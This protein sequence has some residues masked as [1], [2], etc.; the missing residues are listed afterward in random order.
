VCFFKPIVK[1]KN[2]NQLLFDIQVNNRSM[3]KAQ[4]FFITRVSYK[5]TCSYHFAF[6]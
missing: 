3:A 5:M 1:R 4:N 2:A 6:C